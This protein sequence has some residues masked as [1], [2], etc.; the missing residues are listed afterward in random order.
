MSRAYC[1][2]QIF[3]LGSPGSGLYLGTAKNGV[4]YAVL[5]FAGAHIYDAY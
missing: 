2:P 4:P 3:R 5:E 1:V